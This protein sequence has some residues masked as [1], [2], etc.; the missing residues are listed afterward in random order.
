MPYLV[1][2]C[3]LSEGAKRDISPSVEAWFVSVPEEERFISVISLAEIHY[4]ILRLRH[5]RR[6]TELAI[7]YEDSFRP[8]IGTRIVAFGEA[9]AVT[10]AALRAMR[11]NVHHSDS[12][13]AATAITHNLTL[14]TRNVKDFAFEGLAVVNPW[15]YEG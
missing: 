6:R 1:D 7:W 13:I 9:E 3:V 15:E 11:P 2:T 14:V 4:G 5:G 12:Q 8:T 10:W